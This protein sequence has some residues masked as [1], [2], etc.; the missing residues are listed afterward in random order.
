MATLSGTSKT[1]I[2]RVENNLIEPEFSTLY[3]IVEVGLGKKLRWKLIS[4][5]TQAQTKTDSSFS[6][7]IN[8]SDN[9][10]FTSVDTIFITNQIIKG[11]VGYFNRYP[12]NKKLKFNNLC[13]GTYF[14]NINIFHF[15][16]I[17]LQ[18]K[19]EK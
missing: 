6:V 3:K 12:T 1:Y 8:F 4:L 2:S 5:F 9:P 7:Q 18:F 17:P 19:K 13:S 15:L 16:T 14:L 10:A 11:R